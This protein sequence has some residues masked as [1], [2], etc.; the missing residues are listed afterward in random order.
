MGKRAQQSVLFED[1]FDKPVTVA[2]TAPNQ[3]SDGGALLLKAVDQKLGLMQQI[4][5]AL[6]DRRQPG[7]VAH[8]IRELI[9]ERIYAIACGYPDQNDA[10]R[11][12]RDP[13]FRLICNRREGNLASQPTLSRLENSVRRTDLLRVAYALTDNVIAR[14]RRKRKPRKVRRITIDMDPT[15]DPTYG[16]QQLTFFSA[17]YDNW[18][19][20][21]M[22][23]TIQFDRE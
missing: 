19:Y 9:E 6:R 16:D 8:E 21:P 2:F 12:S 15:E 4:A 11:V 7:K 22:T 5:G 18:C 13:I 23:T 14:Q 1:L 17:F 3:S 20:L 10:A